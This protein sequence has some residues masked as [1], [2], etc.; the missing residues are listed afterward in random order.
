[1][2]DSTTRAPAT[3]PARP[4]AVIAFVAAA[5]AMLLLLGP[6]GR[7]EAST[8]LAGC[9]VTPKTP[10]VLPFLD[11]NGNKQ[12][13]YPVAVTCVG[14]RTVQVT[15]LAY[16]EDNGKPGDFGASD[17][18]AG[19]TWI[20]NFNGLVGTKTF[21]PVLAVPDL[22]TDLYVELYHQVSFHVTEGLVTSAQTPFEKSPVLPVH[23]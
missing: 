18:F 13:R 10:E 22:D 8:S 7:A 4:R 11:A 20:W 5:A 12:V 3:Q 15:Q 23:L 21:A 2:P 9:T 1:M 17:K 16:E 14:T 19:W 6:A